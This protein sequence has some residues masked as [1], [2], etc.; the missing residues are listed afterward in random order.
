MGDVMWAGMLTRGAGSWSRLV[1]SPCPTVVIPLPPLSPNSIAPLPPPAPAHPPAAA[2]PLPPPAQ[3][4]VELS[5]GSAVAVTVAKYQTPGGIDIN[6]VG[7]RPTLALDAAQLGA[8][9]LS[10]EAFCRFAQTDA[11]P[12]L[13]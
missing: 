7:I 13:F 6:K 2:A 11:A 3:T 10:G 8:I 12:R 9:P 1:Y 4:L 5:D